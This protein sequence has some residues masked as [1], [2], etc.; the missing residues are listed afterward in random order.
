MRVG[1]G[2]LFLRPLFAKLAFQW[3]VDGP[4]HVVDAPVE[5]ILA[6][7]LCFWVALLG[8]DLLPRFVFCLLS[9]VGLVLF[10]LRLALFLTSVLF[11]AS[12]SQL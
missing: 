10:V 6:M 8:R 1:G 11:V 4:R 12:A 5:G 2:F 3:L 7:L 9:L